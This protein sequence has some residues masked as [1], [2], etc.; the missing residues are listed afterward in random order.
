MSEVGNRKPYRGYLRLFSG[1]GSDRPV[2]AKLL[3]SGPGVPLIPELREPIITMVGIDGFV[4]RGI[5]RVEMQDGVYGVV[6]EW[7]C[8]VIR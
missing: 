6:Q 1:Q 4:L 7:R 2:S 8:A 3:P 5:E